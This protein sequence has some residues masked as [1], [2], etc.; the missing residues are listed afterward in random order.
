MKIKLMALALAMLLA[1]G[2]SLSS[3]A[4]TINDMDSDDVPDA[5]DNCLTHSDGPSTS[6]EEDSDGYVYGNQFHA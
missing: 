4:G 5:F 6:N 2:F 3:T 1:A